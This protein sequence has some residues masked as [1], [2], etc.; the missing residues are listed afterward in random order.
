MQNMCFFC[1]CQ[2]IVIIFQIL[3]NAASFLDSSCYEKF[4]SS[5]FLGRR[6][7]IT[8]D[9]QEI[10]ELISEMQA[11]SDGNAGSQIENSTLKLKIC[12]LQRRNKELL[13]SMDEKTVNFDKEIVVLQ[14]EININKQEIVENRKKYMQIQTMYMAEIND[15]KAR[16][17]KQKQILNNKESEHAE[18]TA[19]LE[20][21]LKTLQISYKIME[22][23][24]KDSAAKTGKYKT[25]V[26]DAIS[27]IQELNK[28]LIECTKR[29]L[30]TNSK[31]G[32]VMLKHEP[33]NAVIS[34]RR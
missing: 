6:V 24:R 22:L 20:N 13:Q 32:H 19:Q 25:K 1:H 4:T 8:E 16:L 23:Q 12:D 15:L 3:N 9:N 18:K 28:V 27:V 17:E 5:S 26:K 31:S 34:H 21:E 11:V 7:K 14:H 33:V 29:I 2:C 10:S 30:T